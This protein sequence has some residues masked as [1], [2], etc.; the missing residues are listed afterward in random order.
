MAGKLSRPTKRRRYKK[1]FLLSVEGQ[2]T[3]PQYFS[4]FNSDASA[5]S[6]RSIKAKSKSAPQKV[7]KRMKDALKEENLKKLTRRG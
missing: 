1:L 3:E 4:L 6:I 7:L 2:K 5:I